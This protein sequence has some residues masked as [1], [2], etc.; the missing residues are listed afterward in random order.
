MLSGASVN[1]VHMLCLTPRIL[2][3]SGQMLASLLMQLV[4]TTTQMPPK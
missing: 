1:A 4:L 2:L 3:V